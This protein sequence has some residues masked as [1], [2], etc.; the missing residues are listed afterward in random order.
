MENI[1]RTGFKL[2]TAVIGNG[3]TTGNPWTNPNN[4]LLTDGDVSQSNPNN[5]A[6][7]VTVGNFNSN[8]P[9]DAVPVGI[10]IK[11][12]GYRGAQTSPPI[13]VTP[14]FVDDTTGTVEFYPYTTP[15]TGLTPESEEY[16]LGGPTY[17]FATEFSVDQINNAKIQLIANG[18]VYMDAILVDVFYYVPEPI[19]PPVTTGDVCVDCN[20]TIQAPSF[21]L[22]LPFFATDTKCYL[23]SFNYSDGTP[24]LYED[25]GS[26]GGYIDLVFDEGKRISQGSNNF[27]ENAQTAIWTVLANGLV[28]VDFVDLSHRGLGFHTPYAHDDALLSDHDANS[29]VII[30]NNGPYEGQRL[31]KCQIGA[32][33]S[34]PIEVDSNDSL[35]AKPVTKI[36]FK[37]AGQTT[38]VNIDN[39]EQV[40][41]VIPG[42]GGT[43]PPVIV[44]TTSGTTGSTPATALTA[45]INISGTNR[46]VPVNISGQQI[47]TIVSVTVG[48]VA[49][50]HS[51]TATDVAHDLRAEEWVCVNP[52]LGVQ[53]VVVT[54]S[55]PT[56]FS[57][58]AECLNSVDTSSPVGATQS[59]TGSSNSP[60][61][62]L[63]TTGDY[64]SIID[65]LCTAQTPILYIPGPGQA[66]NWSA[67][68]NADA[69]QGGSSVQQAGTEPD[70]IT[71]QY[72]ITQNTPW[73]YVAIEIKGITVAPSGV[74]SVTGLNTDNTDPANPVVKVSV[75]GTTITGS[76]T[77]ADPLIAHAGGTAGV[78]YVDV[79]DTTPGYLS[80]KISFS[81][82]DSS[83]TITPSIVNPSGD[84]V[85]NIDL[86]AV[87]PAGVGGG[88][89]LRFPMPL[90]SS[91]TGAKI[92][93]SEIGCDM[94]Q[95]S[96]TYLWLAEDAGSGN[97]YYIYRLDKQSSGNYIYKGV[98]AHLSFASG[99]GQSIHGVTE[100][101]GFVYFKYLNPLVSGQSL[102]TRFTTSLTSPTA[103][104]GIATGFNNGGFTSD[105]NGTTLWSNDSGAS[106]PTHVIPYTVSGTTLVAGSP[107]SLTLTD[108]NFIKAPG[109]DFFQVTNMT[110][111]Q[112]IL[113][114]NSSGAP[115]TSITA[116]LFDLVSGFSSGVLNEGGIG[117]I[118][119]NGSLANACVQYGATNYIQIQ[120]I[121]LP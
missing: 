38:T 106:S 69:R 82:A 109:G 71:M 56:L 73:A 114:W 77:P 52:P 19:T 15:F 103:M 20:S 63:T 30:S 97:G 62:S 120:K 99:S 66:A 61:L 101:G 59:A 117:M 13:T 44:S 119:I 68:A 67:T 93:S 110:G 81:S 121:D 78:V 113:R 95:S 94:S 43:T 111:P 46:A 25:L 70:A 51:V 33:V 7:D 5:A 31:H 14:Y 100:M 108:S 79:D 35:V 22:A 102:V 84:E 21:E 27:M 23:K 11:L 91:V 107:V 17:M 1:I 24:I 40:D 28:E 87:I 2:A 98:N 12:I 42:N 55:A 50:T 115:Q 29:K 10:E 86:Q 37:G 104:T 34:A 89:P 9:Q 75:D 74:Q 105:P 76:G 3:T 53:P 6:S 54:W 36:N 88:A 96:P 16:I 65:G 47:H 85:L 80:D 90:G 8:L 45:S 49:A 39:D 112:T 4:L 26:C 116:Y 58:G 118:R 83:V 92:A 41:V 18:D 64:S 72:S 48:G 32:L 60:M 57:F